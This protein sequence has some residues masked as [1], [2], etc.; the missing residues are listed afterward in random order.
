[1][2]A[3]GVLIWVNDLSV[4]M[5]VANNNSIYTMAHVSVCFV[6]LYGAYLGLTYGHSGRSCA[7]YR[8][9]RILCRSSGLLVGVLG[10]VMGVGLT[11]CR[12]LPGKPSGSE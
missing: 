11:A 10:P 12:L 4:D 3:L 1:M 5:V 2:Y 7:W 6:E 9:A 8:Q